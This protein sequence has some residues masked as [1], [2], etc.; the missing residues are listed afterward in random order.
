MVVR[1]CGTRIAGGI[2]LVV[3]TGKK[4]FPLEAFLVDPPRPVDPETI[5][6]APQGVSLV[7]D[8]H[9]PE[10]WHVVDW[11]GTAHYPNATDFLEEARRHGVS[12]RAQATLPFS[13][14]GPKSRLLIVHPRGFFVEADVMRMHQRGRFKPCE[15]GIAGHDD[16]TAMCVQCLWDDVEGG[17][18]EIFTRGDQTFREVG[19]TTYVGHEPLDPRPVASPAIIA[20]FPLRRIE[21]V[22]DP[23]GGKHERAMTR[24]QR[25][26]IDVVQADE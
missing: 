4:G 25:A 3:P 6:L 10:V 20:S 17:S 1:A 8:P 7:I 15:R 18:P 11:V 5:G 14:I 12:R 26:G 13:Q 23:K 2:Y 21:V 22:T 19:G 9:D 16:G 24:A